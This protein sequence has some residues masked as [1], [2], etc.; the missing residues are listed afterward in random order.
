MEAD[1]EALVKALAVT[2]ALVVVQVA[3]LGLEHKALEHLVKVVLGGMVLRLLTLLAV[4]AAV[5]VLL[6]QMD[7]TLPRMGLVA[8]V[9]LD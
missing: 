3:L 2:V 4:V 1:M 6:G 5:K 9:V 8:L 7:K